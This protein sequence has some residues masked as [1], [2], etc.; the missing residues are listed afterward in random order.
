[1]GEKFFIS[2]FRGAETN[3]LDRPTVEVTES[4][5]EL[6]WALYLP[7]NEVY[8][9]TNSTFIFKNTIYCFT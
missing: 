9:K 5:V 6:T 8:P 7:G 3:R 2:D 4:H 1:M